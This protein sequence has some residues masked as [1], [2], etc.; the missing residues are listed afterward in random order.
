[1]LARDIGQRMLMKSNV[2]CEGVETVMAV[3][4]GSSAGAAVG[5]VPCAETGE[6]EAGAARER[7]GAVRKR[8]S[9]KPE[10][11]AKGAGRFGSG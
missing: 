7:R 4:V 8:I 5:G 6:S 9:R 1:M 11:H 2:A 3:R 10:P